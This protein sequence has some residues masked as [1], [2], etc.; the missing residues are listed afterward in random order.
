[1]K[2][3]KI[4]VDFSKPCIKKYYRI[5][6]YQARKVWIYWKRKEIVLRRRNW[7]VMMKLKGIQRKM[8]KTTQR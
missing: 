1:M 5:T 4:M 2:K 8:V 3:K 6:Q 7:S